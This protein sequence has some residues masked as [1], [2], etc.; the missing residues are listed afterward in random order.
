MVLGAADG[1][2]E[3]ESERVVPVA[4]GRCSCRRAGAFWSSGAETPRT[5]SLRLQTCP[6]TCCRWTAA[7]GSR[8]GL[9]TLC[10]EYLNSSRITLTRLN[11]ETKPLLGLN[12]TKQQKL[13]YIG[14]KTIH[15]YSLKYNFATQE[16]SNLSSQP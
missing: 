13:I 16:S 12:G 6:L 10:C 9:T 1:Q 2:T 5:P 14:G 15:F 3:S 11:R 4:P 7:F 8:K